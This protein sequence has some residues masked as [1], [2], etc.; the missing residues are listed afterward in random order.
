M[1][2]FPQTFPWTLSRD[3]FP[4]NM[5]PIHTWHYHLTICITASWVL[6]SVGCFLCVD[7]LDHQIVY[8]KS[9]WN[10]RLDC[11]WLDSAQKHKTNQQKPRK[12]TQSDSYCVMVQGDLS[13]LGRLMMQ[14]DLEVWSDRKK[15][16]LPRHVF[17]YERCFLLCKKKRDEANDGHVYSYKLS[18]Q[19]G[20]MHR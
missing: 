19:V 18:I 1:W 12:N 13:S 6:Q 8:F 2:T 4:Q 10:T 7:N 9:F 11:I 15:D 17:L 20:Y 3:S 5:L 16:R 14:G